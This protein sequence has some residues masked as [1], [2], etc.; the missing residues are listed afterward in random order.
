MILG[1]LIAHLATFLIP[2]ARGPL[3]I[4]SAVLVAAQIFGDGPAT[5]Y[6][7]NKTSLLQSATSDDL[8]GRVNASLRV[9]QLGATLVGSLGARVLGEL[10]GLRWTLLTAAGIGMI[11]WL[12]LAL[13]PVRRLDGDGVNADGVNADG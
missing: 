2:L 8:L 9:V 5:I 4:A 1:A 12:R 3:M 6:A 7:I 13:S 10:I 11:A